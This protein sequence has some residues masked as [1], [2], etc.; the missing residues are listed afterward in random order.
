MAVAD[1]CN[2][3]AANASISSPVFPSPLTSRDS[4]SFPP[5]LTV[6]LPASLLPS[7]FTLS[8]YLLPPTLFSST[9]YA[10]TER[11]APPSLRYLSFALPLFLFSAFSP[12]SL[13]LLSN[14][15]VSSRRCTTHVLTEQRTSDLCGE[16]VQPSSARATL[17][18]RGSFRR[19]HLALL[20]RLSRR[21]SSRLET[22]RCAGD[23]GTIHLEHPGS[24]VAMACRFTTRRTQDSRVQIKVLSFRSFRS[25]PDPLRLAHFNAD[26][27]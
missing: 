26:K 18:R 2:S 4:S 16:S 12:T 14:P 19:K 11:I 9:L 3:S 10:P 25:C 8:I 15:L 1:R 13:R 6:T 5:Y 21:L 22:V 7:Y 20:S 24:L 27:A 23:P 17:S